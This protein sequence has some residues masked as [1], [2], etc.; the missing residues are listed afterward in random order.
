MEVSRIYLLVA[1]FAAQTTDGKFTASGIFS[2]INI[3]KGKDSVLLNIYAFGRFIAPNMDK[4]KHIRLVILDPN[5]KQIS[6]A[7]LSPDPTNNPAVEFFQFI[8]KFSA[9]FTT[10]GQ[11]SLKMFFDD[12][13]VYTEKDYFRVKKT[14]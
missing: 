11:Y 10:E 13:E 7:I 6:E 2:R 4:V 14:A 5:N 12:R 8:A 3:P 1:E 9:N